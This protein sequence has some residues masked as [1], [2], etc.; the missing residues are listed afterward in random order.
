MAQSDN[1]PARIGN[2]GTSRQFLAQVLKVGPKMKAPSRFYSLMKSVGFSGPA[3]LKEIEVAQDRL[4]VIFPEQYTCFLSTFGASIV[5]E[6]YIFGLPPAPRPGE[7]PLW[8][9][10]LNVNSVPR[11][12]PNYQHFLD[13]SH[14]GGDVCIC[15]NA[16]KSPETE[17]W[18]LG[19]GVER[20]V[21]NDFF[22]FFIGIANG[23]HDIF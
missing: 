15:L 11:A 13:I 5:R 16:K 21:S 19:P 14:D 3:T 7:T 22:E 1:L 9:S 23:S 4:G 20:I 8:E 10:L 18:S 12:D 6:F 17:I 2:K